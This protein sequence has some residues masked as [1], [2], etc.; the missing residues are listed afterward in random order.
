MALAPTCAFAQSARAPDAASP[1]EDG[2]WTMPAKDAANT[3]YSGLNEITR[4]NVKNL[5][6][7]FAVSTGTSSGN[8]SAVLMAQ[9]T[10]YFV[11][12]YPNI[13]FAIDMTKPGGPIKWRFDPN[14]D[15]SA[16]G[17]ACCEAVNRGPFYSNGTIYYNT[18]DMHTLAIDASTGALKWKTKLGDFT[19]GETMTMAPFVVKDKVLVGNSGAEFG[20][21]GWITALNARDGSIAWR[22]Y[23]TGP[24]KDVL[25]EENTF[26]PFYPQYKGKDLG[27]SQWPVGAWETGGGT[28]WGWISYD[29]EQNLIFHGTSNPAPWN[30]ELRPGDN[31]W[32]NGVFAREPETG[33]ARWFYQYSP[34]DLFDHSAV[35][36][37]I[38]LDIPWEGKQRKVIVRPE[39]NG[40]VYVIDRTNGEVLAADQF[41][42]VNASKGIDLKT[43][44]LAYAPEKIPATGKMTRNV[45]PN[46][47][48]AKDWSPS[49]FSKDTGLLYV[50][51]NNLCMDWLPT[52]VSYIAGTP[53][54]GVE[55]RFYPGPGGNA[56]AFMAWD[57][58]NRKK[59]WENK[60]RWP[61]WSGAMVTAGGVVFYGDLEGWFKALD[62]KTGE[63]LWRFQTG[64]GIIGQPTTFRGP[65]GRQYVAILSGIGGW[66]GSIVSKDLDH[67]D[68]TA[69][70]GFANMTGDLKQLT[71]KGG[72][73]YVFALPR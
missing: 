46:A 62:A 38:V 60:E 56:G 35:N 57:P 41:V 52:E 55:T 28:V 11:T 72:M 9:N 21:R 63:L 36:E 44:R 26:K 50:P 65:D 59:V 8:E 71:R 33:K 15:A 34:H 10:L 18:I 24:D 45:C 53:Y 16:Q 12:P 42:H 7:E 49:A 54:I 6:V 51:H 39:R 1:T 13:L 17:Q 40:Y 70:K 37:N 27:V 30:H 29:P 23:S 66:V 3:R 5:K 47:P 43:G 48:G 61:V 4:D 20:A 2:Q 64:S 68:A 19:K 14:P 25:I 67:R 58:V 69:Q 32:T 73:L 22:A 31:H